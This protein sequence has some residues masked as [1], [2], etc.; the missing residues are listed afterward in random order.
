MTIQKCGKLWQV[1]VSVDGDRVRMGGLTF[2]EVRAFQSIQAR[3]MRK[4]GRK[5]TTRKRV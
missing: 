3:H 5:N 4:L 2:K 1:D